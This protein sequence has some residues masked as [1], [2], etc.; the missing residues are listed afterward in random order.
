MFY[1]REAA[2]LPTPRERDDV[3]VFQGPEA[4]APYPTA[5]GDGGNGAD[6]AVDDAPAAEVTAE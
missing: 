2:R 5:R 4:T 6:G 3:D 1:G